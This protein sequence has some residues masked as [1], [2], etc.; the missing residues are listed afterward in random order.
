MNVQTAYAACQAITRGEARN[1]SYGIALLPA[2]QRRAMTA[3]YA[4]ARR[5]DDIGDGDLPDAEKERALE[6]LRRS[7]LAV[8]DADRPA[9][10]QVDPV[11]LALA[12]AA[13]RF[14]LPLTAFGEIVDGCLADVSV[15]SYRTFDELVEYCRCVAGAVGRLSVGIYRPR[16][17][18]EAWEPADAL[19][20]A[21]QITNILRDV[22]EDRLAG[23]I[24]LPAE[25]LER[26]GCRLDIDDSGALTDPP[27]AFAALIRFQA[28]RAQI[29]Y[30]RG[31]ALLPLLDRRS[32]A[33]TAA[34]AGIYHRLLGIIA[35]DPDAVR[36][37]RVS[38]PAA[39]KAAVAARAL[40]RGSW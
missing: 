39:Q 10:D 23:R 40:A 26:F 28:E 21:L 38:L 3:V 30:D 4:A 11:L 29:W 16:R 24:Y 35:A 5:I 7:L 25:D 18:S 17:L 20:V 22:R 6:S 19:G 37:R 15:H 8:R 2:A 1:F 14:P 9:A 12:D 27:D 32:A 31:A 36:T 13:E 34:M 33:C